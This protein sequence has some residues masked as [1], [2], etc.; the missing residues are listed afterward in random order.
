MTEYFLPTGYGQSE[1]VEKKSRFLGKVWP[2][3][4]EAEAREKSKR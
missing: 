3:S 4:T 2:V 1:F